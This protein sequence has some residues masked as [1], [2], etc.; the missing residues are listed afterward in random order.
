MIQQ[1]DHGCKLVVIIY[2]TWSTQ[3][4][5]Y[6]VLNSFKSLKQI[7]IPIQVQFR[8]QKVTEFPLH[9]TTS[10]LN[11]IFNTF[12][13]RLGYR[14]SLGITQ[15]SPA[16]KVARDLRFFVNYL[17]IMSTYR[18][19]TSDRPSSFCDLQCCTLRVGSLFTLITGF[20]TANCTY[21]YTGILADDFHEI[22]L[23]H[24]AQNFPF[25]AGLL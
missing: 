18:S 6:S 23:A 1:A 20:A 15:S 24:R 25:R 8:R 21:F 5:M 9:R 17:L 19:R 16:Q 12:S 14:H 2:L 11:V 3:R 10:L 22:A 13:H 4:D 7:Y